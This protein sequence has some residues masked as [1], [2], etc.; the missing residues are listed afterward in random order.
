[1]EVIR[2][3]LQAA[4]DKLT[5]D[6]R[7]AWGILT[8]QHMV[9]HLEYFLHMA[10]GKIET[11]ITTP[12]ER[13]EKFQESLYNHRL[14]PRSFDHPQLRKG[15]QEDLRHESLSAAKAA[16]FE[17]YDAYETFFKEH[18][19]ITT[20]NTVFGMLDKELWDLI[21][22]KHFTHHFTQFGLV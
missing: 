15:A 18:P 1:M 20:P 16:F 19:E 17:A 9:E 4:L 11:E 14:M 2:D 10:V 7:P 6:T 21:G 13:I 12:P 8:P 22:R 5:E 3:R